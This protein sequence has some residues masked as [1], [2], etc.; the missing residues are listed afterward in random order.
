MRFGIAQID[1]TPPFP[2]G[3]AGYG[4]RDDFYDDVS[5]PLTFTALILEE[6]GRRAVIGAADLISFEQD[7][8]MLLRREIAE[9]IKAPV[10]NVMLNTSHTHGGP[11]LN[12]RSSYFR[13]GQTIPS[14]KRYRDWLEGQVLASVKDAAK[15]MEPGTLWFG[16]GK[17]GTPMNRRLLRNGEIVNAP[18]PDGP[19]DDRLQVLVLRDK[20]DAIRAV[21]I[22]LSCHP[23]ATGAQHRITADYPGAFRAAF[24]YAFGP[25]ITPFFLQGAG[26]DMRPGQVDDGDRWRKMAHDELHVIGESLLA[27]TVGVMASGKMEKLGPL[28][29]KGKLNVAQVPCEERMTTRGEFEELLKSG[30]AGDKMWAQEALRHIESDGQ[31]LSSAPIRV[32]TLWLTKDLAAVGIQGE[33]LVGMGAY[34]E[35]KMRPA[36]TLLLGYT[37]GCRCYLPDSKELARGGYEQGS[38]RYGGWTGPFKKGIEKVIAGAAWRG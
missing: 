28:V 19:V 25:G 24:A 29:L 35:R 33:V 38:Y 17:S 22:R 16:Q 15:N 8:V 12:D 10:D 21:G 27:E 30:S 13:G 36:R 6:R 14:A 3:M 31:A 26:G 34:V 23:V 32:H 37:N 2:T 9:A 11:Q 1:I 5:D 18:N 4:A 20:A 7:H